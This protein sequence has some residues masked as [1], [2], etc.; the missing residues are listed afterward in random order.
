MLGGSYPH[1]L[2]FNQAITTVKSYG[3][4]QIDTFDYAG[5]NVQNFELPVFLQD[6]IL[7]TKYGPDGQAGPKPAPCNGGTID[8]GLWRIALNTAVMRLALVNADPQHPHQLLRDVSLNPALSQ[9]MLGSVLNNP[10]FSGRRLPRDCLIS[11]SC[12]ARE[13]R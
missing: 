11:R 10:A 3:A 1:G 8:L 2:P 5:I 4:F 13:F 12:S 6:G 7:I 9:S